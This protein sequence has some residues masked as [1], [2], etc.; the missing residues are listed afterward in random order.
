MNRLDVKQRARVDNKLAL[1]LVPVK[2]RVRNR[3][4]FVFEDCAFRRARRLGTQGE[5]CQV[6]R[7][8][9]DRG[10]SVASAVAAQ[11]LDAGRRGRRQRVW[12]GGGVK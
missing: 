4:L 11:A 6:Q 10:R 12:V 2:N 3:S 5:R 1:C 7:R 8:R 9:R